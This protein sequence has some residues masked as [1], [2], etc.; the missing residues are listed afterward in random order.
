MIVRRIV[1]MAI[2]LTVP[3][4]SQTSLPQGTPPA[5][6]APQTDE[7]TAT[8][9]RYAMELYR[10]GKF[11]ESLPW[12]EK[13]VVALPNNAEV[14]TGLGT[15]LMNQ[16]ATLPDPAQRKATRIR[17][18]EQFLKAKELG[19][20]DNF[21]PIALAG[22]PEDGSDP[23]FS[24]SPEID[25]LMKEGEAA[26]AAGKLD[27]AKKAYLAV[28]VL[29]PKNYEA[30]LFMG[31]VYFSKH[32]ATAAG[33][34]FSRAIQ[35]DPDRETA[36]RY[37]ADALLKQGKPAAAREKYVA[38]VLC[39]PYDRHVWAGVQNYLR[40]TNQKATWYKITPK[41]SFTSNGK[42]G[43][44]TIDPSSTGNQGSS[45]AWLTYSMERALWQGEKFAKAYPQEKQYRHSLREESEALSD[46]ASVAQKMV[47]DKKDVKL[48]PDLEALVKLK[49]EGFLDAYVL[50]NAADEGI[51]KDYVAYR[52]EHR[53][54]LL[55]YLDEVVLPAAPPDRS[56][57]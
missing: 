6:A 42:G 50:L 43:T 38:A 25:R 20:E 52:N 51:A 22:L 8:D 2:V 32:D 28:V 10:E 55:R 19:D 11:L 27:E 56:D 41:S 4:L 26:F 44:I 49:Q 13:L 14:R 15:A 3:L 24:E 16:A 36:Y 12:F 5:A 37:W 48:D 45:A 21:V 1:L 18:R 29:D 46:V 35:L 31:D 34:W 39:N 9:R 53:D 33:E 57:Q 40:L 17:A 30:L 47:V 23:H 7:Q 54:L